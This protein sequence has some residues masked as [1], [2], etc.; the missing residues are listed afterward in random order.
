MGVVDVWVGG[1]TPPL[2]RAGSLRFAAVIG[3]LVSSVVRFLLYNLN[4]S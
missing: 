4:A 3:H 2:V 1:I